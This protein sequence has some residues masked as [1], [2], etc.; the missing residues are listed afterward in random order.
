M[1]DH[2][3]RTFSPSILLQLNGTKAPSTNTEA[4]S[5]AAMA[6]AAAA[7]FAQSAQT[8]QRNNDPAIKMARALEQLQKNPVNV[9]AGPDNRITILHI[10]RFLPGPY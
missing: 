1:P 8:A 5:N 9:A 7:H 6:A 3:F 2:V 10:A 4:Q